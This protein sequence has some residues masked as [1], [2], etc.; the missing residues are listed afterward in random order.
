MITIFPMNE[1]IS[2]SNLCKNIPSL[3]HKKQWF[4]NNSSKSV[5][6]NTQ[7][8]TTSPNHHNNPIRRGD[9]NVSLFLDAH[10]RRRSNNKK[11][12]SRTS[13]KIGNSNPQPR[14]RAYIQIS[15]NKLRSRAHDSRIQ[16]Q[17]RCCP[18]NSRRGPRV[19]LSRKKG[20]RNSSTPGR[21][22]LCSP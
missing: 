3:L 18:Y 17:T 11:T 7:P 20:P 10:A 12:A 4:S 14:S 22:K 19:N 13:R 5:H 6:S 8:H 16:M 2:Q 9:Y 21:W 1:S 15:N